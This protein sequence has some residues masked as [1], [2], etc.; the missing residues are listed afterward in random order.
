MIIDRWSN[1]IKLSYND[2]NNLYALAID[3]QLQRDAISESRNSRIVMIIAL[4]NNLP[5]IIV[6]TAIKWFDGFILQRHR[7]I[8]IIVM[9]TVEKNIWFRDSPLFMSMTNRSCCYSNVIKSSSIP[10]PILMMSLIR[11]SLVIAMSRWNTAWAK[12]QTRTRET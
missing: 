10:R 2:V 9:G 11:F 8:E 6:L 4:S 12:N 5:E 1:S 7:I 3:H